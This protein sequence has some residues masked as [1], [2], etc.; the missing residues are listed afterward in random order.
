MLQL[1]MLYKQDK[2]RGR[3]EGE[4]KVIKSCR[5]PMKKKIRDGME[6]PPGVLM[7]NNNNAPVGDAVQQVTASARGA[8]CF[9]LG[10]GDTQNWGRDKLLPPVMCPPVGSNLH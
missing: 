2:L 4:K 3:G 7:P 6:I 8:W 10:G 9:Y 1:E 5:P